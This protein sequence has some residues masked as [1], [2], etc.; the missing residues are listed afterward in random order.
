MPSFR[1]RMRA[2]FRSLTREE[3][4]TL[5]SSFGGDVFT[6]C[7][8]QTAHDLWQNELSIV[9]DAL[10]ARP[11]SW[12]DAAE[13]CLRRDEHYNVIVADAVWKHANHDH[14][15]NFLFPLDFLVASTRNSILF[16]FLSIPSLGALGCVSKTCHVWVR[17]Y[18]HDAG[19]RT[20]RSDVIFLDR[21][22]KVAIRGHEDGHFLSPNSC[23]TAIFVNKV[24][25]GSRARI[26]RC[27]AYLLCHRVA[28]VERELLSSH[29]G[30]NLL[31]TLPDLC[32]VGLLQDFT[33]KSLMSVCSH[34]YLSTSDLIFLDIGRFP[35]LASI[36]VV[37]DSRIRALPTNLEHL[38]HTVVITGQ[39]N[40][41]FNNF[42]SIQAIESPSIDQIE[43]CVCVFL[44]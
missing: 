35:K 18:S 10:H 11:D 8:A 31:E 20:K 21:H 38:V 12:R 43:E 19:P 16:A 22:N 3:C 17:N 6:D 30:Q 7:V 15:L 13:F 41:R 14:I 5:V 44:I 33:Q 2:T 40:F 26:H 25:T 29:H 37:V 42:S 39:I 1:E 9:R 36:T 34:L 28:G 4:D 32:L 27:P 24:L 23:A